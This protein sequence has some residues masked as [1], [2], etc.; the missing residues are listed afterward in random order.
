MG[1]SSEG[2]GGAEPLRVASLETSLL[3]HLS[4]NGELRPSSPDG[5]PPSRRELANSIFKPVD[6]NSAWEKALGGSHRHKTFFT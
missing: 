3:R 4:S 5:P 6:Y 2:L 1:R